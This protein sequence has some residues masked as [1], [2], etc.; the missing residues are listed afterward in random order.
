MT[1]TSW[2]DPCTRRGHATRGRLVSSAMTS[3]RETKTIAL[4]T[5]KRDGTPVTTPV[6]IAFDGDRA[7]FRT[8]HTA[9]KAKRLRNEP[10]VEVAPSTLAGRPTAPA[11][12]MRAR[13]LSGAEAT[14]AAR[15]LAG[16]H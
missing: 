13:R 4:T 14:L 1:R 2:G 11:V 16:R 3:L 9:G 12:T 6:S 10:R 5:F 8:W 15:T 7:F